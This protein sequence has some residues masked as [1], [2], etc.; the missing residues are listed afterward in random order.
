MPKKNSASTSS[1]SDDE[2]VGPAREEHEQRQEREQGGERQ[3]GA[4]D[5]RPHRLAAQQGG[6]LLPPPLALVREQPDREQ[7]EHEAADVGEVRHAAAAAP[8]PV[9]RSK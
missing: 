4:H 3:R 2:H 5:E 9:A 8:A 6:L 7:P 1:D